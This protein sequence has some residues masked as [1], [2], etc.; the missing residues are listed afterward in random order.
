MVY[1]STPMLDVHVQPAPLRSLSSSLSQ[2]WS[3][4]TSNSHNSS[5]N[6]YLWERKAKQ[7]KI[8]NYFW[9][10]TSGGSEK[11]HFIN[12]SLKRQQEGVVT[13]WL[14]KLVIVAF[15][16][17]C[18]MGEGRRSWRRQ[19]TGQ[20]GVTQAGAHSCRAVD[21]HSTAGLEQDSSHREEV[22]RSSRCF[23]FPLP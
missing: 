2:L 23:T 11:K 22:A 9:P 21:P 14:E 3:A 15:A 12:A 19:E 8:K 5:K 6:T 13:L 10:L 20:P 7:R 17:H 16:C 4:L 18:G 1:P